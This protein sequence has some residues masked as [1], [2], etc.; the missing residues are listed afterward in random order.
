MFPY[1]IVFILIDISFRKQRSTCPANQT[2][3]SP[4]TE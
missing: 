2:S 1:S 3:S 4:G